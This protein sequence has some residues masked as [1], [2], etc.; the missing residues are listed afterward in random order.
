M[1]ID[2]YE[3]LADRICNPGER[4]SDIYDR[5]SDQYGLDMATFI[6]IVDSLMRFTP[7]IPRMTR[8]RGVAYTR[9]FADDGRY[10]VSQVVDKP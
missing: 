2:N 7:V 10:I 6:A 9:G 8:E 5:L 3:E 1:I 4:G